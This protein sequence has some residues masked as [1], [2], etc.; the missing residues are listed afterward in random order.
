MTNSLAFRRIL[1]IFC[2]LMF[3]S[4]VLFFVNVSDGN[5]DRIQKYFDLPHLIFYTVFPV[6]FYLNLGWLFPELFLRK[7]FLIYFGIMALLFLSV[8][9]LEPFEGLMASNN[10]N[11]P[12]HDN[13]PPGAITGNRKP[14]PPRPPLYDDGGE[15][16]NPQGP[17][18]PRDRRNPKMDIMSVI[19]FILT[20]SISTGLGV[21][22][23]WRTTE[24]RAFKAEA[25][26]AK[27]ELSFLKAQVNPHFLFNTL[28]NIY[29][30]AITKNPA[31]AESIM[32]LSNIMRYI[33]DDVKENFVMLEN[34]IDC[35]RDYIDLQRIRLGNTTQV[36]FE[37]QGQ[38]ENMK[39]APL[40]LMTFVE[41]AFKYGTSNHEISIIDISITVGAKTILFVCTNK[42]FVSK[43]VPERTG[44]GI[45]NAKQRLLSLY[46]DSHKLDISESGGYYI[47]NLELKGA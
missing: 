42:L 3:F 23:Q 10:R 29:S 22:R 8:F 43:R 18:G 16:R 1:H 44:I 6:I 14:P 27:A 46:P 9:Y 34:E 26:K 47:V 32:K 17:G 20:W 39:I 11:E 4:M 25:D 36:N 40:L 28:N 24:Q 13:R 31:T 41:N 2:W 35:L 5:E 12:P 15:F 7:R 38:Q 19:I 30:M 37:I 33:T 45:Q 21:F